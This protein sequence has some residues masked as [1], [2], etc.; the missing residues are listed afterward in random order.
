MN[1]DNDRAADARAAE[2]VLGYYWAEIPGAGGSRGLYAPPNR[3]PVASESDGQR[4]YRST[5][6]A[7]GED[8]NAARQFVHALPPERRGAFAEALI[9]AVDANAAIAGQF[10]MLADAG[11][12]AYQIAAATPRQ[13]R[14]AVLAAMEGPLDSGKIAT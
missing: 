11:E 6:P 10:V 12:F 3:L 13:L 9:S 2:L 5:L 8:V 1:T 7:F 14:D 4:Y